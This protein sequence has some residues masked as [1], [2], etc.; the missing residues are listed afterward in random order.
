MNFSQISRR[1]VLRTGVAATASLAFAHPLLS[2]AQSS[3]PLITRPIPSTGEQVPVIGLGTNAYTANSP[4]DMAPL[5]EVLDNMHRLGGTVIDTARVYGR[6]EEVI[7]EILEELDNRDSYFVASKTPMGGDFSNP[8]AVLNVSFDRLRMDRIDLM[9]I[10][11]LAG[12]A[13]LMPSLLRAKEQGRIRYVGMSTSSDN[14]YPGIM[15]AMREYPLDVIQVDYSIDN[16][17]AANEVL[18][19]AQER[20]IAVMINTP[21]GGRRNAAGLFAQTRDLQLPD[22]AGSIDVT[23][24]A[25]FFLKYVVSHPA[26][27][28]AIPGTTRLTNLQDNQ[29][30]GRGR[31]PDADMRREIETYWESVRS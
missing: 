28:V 10:H 18:P 19:L 15:A 24:W 8:E 30:A 9:M 1:E 25:Q 12:T 29:G 11:N 23:S 6:S 3:L 5:R 2:W 20:G 13:E 7:G 22:F 27:T 26:V 21:F 31:L 17:T 4:E 14:Q 16:R